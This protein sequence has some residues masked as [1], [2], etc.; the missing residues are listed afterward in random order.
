MIGAAGFYGYTLTNVLFLTLVWHY[1]VLGAGLALTP[2]P[3]VAMAVAG[4]TSRLVERIGHRPV[5]VAG[6]LIWGSAVL[7]LVARM[8]LRPDFFGTWL[9]G[10]IW[11][12]LG[13]GTLFPNLSSAAV[14]SAPGEGF[15]TAT[16]LNSVAR[17]LGAAIGVAIAVALIGSPSPAD[18]VSNFHHA[19]AF[20]AA[21]LLSAG[22]GSLA[23]GRLR[24]ERAPALAAAARA[25]MR[26]ASSV[27]AA[28]AAPRARRAI[29]P[30]PAPVAELRAETTAE[31]LAA[32]PLFA[33]LELELREQLAAGA[34]TVTVHAGEW[35]FREGDPA[36]ATYVVRTGRL[37]VVDEST[38]SVIRELG[39]GDALGELALLTDSTRS[40]SVRALRTSELLAIGR[41]EFDAALDSSPALP[42]ALARTLAAQ[43]RDT[44]APVAAKRPLPVTVALVA[45][46]PGVPLDGLARGLREACAV[47]LAAELLDGRELPEV[48]EPGQASAVYAPAVDR[49]ESCSRLVLLAAGELAE[50]TP[51]GEFCLQ[52]ADR[53]LAVLGP[54][55]VS[56]AVLERPELRGC[57]LVVLDL[58]LGAA[59]QGAIAE[60]LD[61]IESHVLSS[62]SLA[63][64]LARVARRLCGQSIGI[65]LSGGG[66]RAFSHI[67]VLDE[68]LAAGVVID[69]VAGVSMGAVVGAMFAMGL[70]PAAIDAACF[71]EWVQRRPL[72]D[73]TVPRHALIR[74]EPAPRRAVRAGCRGL[75]GPCRD[76]PPRRPTGRLRRAGAQ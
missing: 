52:Q 44:R 75:R 7:W 23:V 61:P 76:G 12:G 62:G 51:W 27:A 53:I 57:D 69:R 58:A 1:S 20:G 70:D 25:V 63:D 40:A 28:P 19:W 6:G 14:A 72:A 26:P 56:A 67:G 3:L 21:C 32:V 10:V 16:G 8:G 43:L 33:G 60:A 35:L 24:V 17:Q 55:G 71:D 2:G 18:V 34:R 65:V 47:H 59:G 39:R 4:P 30:G 54:G 31:F 37:E 64:D 42:L 49:A 68:L 15:A 22:L 41:D 45:L 13:A 73:Y 9:P 48:S 29:V 36:Q 66:A 46:G 5:L 38:G 11:L 50:V 74:G